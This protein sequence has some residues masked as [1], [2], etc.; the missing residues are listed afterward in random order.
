VTKGKAKSKKSGESG[1]SK[2]ELRKTI[3]EIL[4]KVDFNTVSYT[5]IIKLVNE[6]SE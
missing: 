3:C 5:V 1:P 2:E 4:N 6:R